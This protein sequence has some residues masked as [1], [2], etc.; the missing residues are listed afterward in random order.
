MNI[1]KELK[2]DCKSIVGTIKTYT[3]QAHIISVCDGL[4]SA[5]NRNDL[6]EIKY[7]L[8]SISEWYEDN[9]NEIQSNQYVMDKKTHIKI[10]NKMDTY[11]QGINRLV[12]ENFSAVESETLDEV[13][14]VNRNKIFIVHGHDELA[15]EQ[16]ISFV[17]DIK[18]EPIVLM[19]QAS[20]GKTIIEKIEQYS[21]VGYA[22]V[23][24]TPCDIG[25]SKEDESNKKERARQNV[26]FEH[27]YLIAKLGR[28]NVC[29]LVKGDVEKPNDI[30]GVVYIELD[31]QKA[32][33]FKIA[34]EM[35]ALGY[36]IDLN[37]LA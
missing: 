16:T 12:E 28:K 5:L 10:Q 11:I 19:H 23:L 21:D 18:L 34:K 17:K 33:R 25:F 14:N 4:T 32:W 24:Y 2:L 20:V 26:I 31:N 27:G 30:S 3:S 15:L 29:A 1:L 6:E 13:I 9:Q 7:Y 8:E 35:K 37:N 36:D 22:I